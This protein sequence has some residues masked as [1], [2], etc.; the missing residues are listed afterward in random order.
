MWRCRFFLLRTKNSKVI[1]CNCCFFSFTSKN[2]FHLTL[3]LY[4]FLLFFFVFLFNRGRQ[5]RRTWYPN[6]EK[7]RIIFYYWERGGGLFRTQAIN[8]EVLTRWVDFFLDSLPRSLLFWV[9][10]FFFL[11]D[12]IL[13]KP[14]TFFQIIFAINKASIFF[15][16]TLPCPFHGRTAKIVA[17]KL[18]LALCICHFF[19]NPKL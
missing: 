2:Y 17:A 4:F 14:A 6:K 5:V 8:G 13:A 10:F 18:S 7:E 15:L 3:L 1:L 12:T 9:L 16:N 11:Y 19:F